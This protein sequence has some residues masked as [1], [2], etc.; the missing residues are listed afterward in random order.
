MLTLDSRSR[1]EEFKPPTR[2]SKQFTRLTVTGRVLS[3]IMLSGPLRT[4]RLLALVRQS[5]GAMFARA[6]P[7]RQAKRREGVAITP[8]GPPFPGREKD[9]KPLGKSQKGKTP[10]CA[11]RLTRLL[12]WILGPRPR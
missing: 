7:A 4:I 5:M 2:T 1:A 9:N 10:M 12:H 3:F 6:R 11:S 8:R